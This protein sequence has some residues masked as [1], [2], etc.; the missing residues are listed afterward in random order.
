MVVVLCCRACILSIACLRTFLNAGQ[1]KD[2]SIPGGT[3]TEP[4]VDGRE[5]WRARVRGEYGGLV[6]SVGAD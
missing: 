2:P 1:T 3:F 5:R 6:D 4:G